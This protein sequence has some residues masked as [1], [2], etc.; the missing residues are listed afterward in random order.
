M[1]CRPSND[2]GDVVEYQVR[3]ESMV[4]LTRQAARNA[5]EDVRQRL[6]AWRLPESLG[7]SVFPTPCT[8]CNLSIARFGHS[9]TAAVLLWLQFCSI[10]RQ[11]YIDV[12]WPTLNALQNP[13]SRWLYQVCILG[14]GAAATS[15]QLGHHGW[16]LRCFG[17]DTQ[18]RL[19]CM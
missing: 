14:K 7:V 5:T 9:S 17:C 3:V 10:T 11:F 18:P 15:A 2:A 16:V 4:D 8:S 1:L 19:I 13:A 12:V 6:A